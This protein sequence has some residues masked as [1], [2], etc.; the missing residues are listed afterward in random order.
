[1]PTDNPSS[2]RKMFVTGAALLAGLFILMLTMPACSADAQAVSNV[3]PA[4][5]TLA[6]EQPQTVVRVVVQKT[7]AEIYI[8]ELIPRLGGTIIQTL[9]VT[10]SIVAEMSAE[11]AVNLAQMDGVYRVNLETDKVV[12]S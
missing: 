2:Q 8:E 3:Q 12:E 6:A 10:N 7:S 1:M 5:L 11:M 4:L 9:P